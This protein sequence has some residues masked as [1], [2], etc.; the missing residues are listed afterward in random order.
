M[1]INK[2]YNLTFTYLLCLGILFQSC[3]K[4]LNIDPPISSIEQDLVF[5]N[6]PQATSAVVG[7]YSSMNSN[8]FASG[9]TTSVTFYAGMS[10]DDLIGY[11]TIL[12]FYENHLVAEL[13]EINALYNDFYRTIYKANVILEGLDASSS[14]SPPVKAQLQGE[15]YF[16]RSFANFYLVNLFGPIPLPLTSDYRTTE[17][18]PRS[19]VEA[20][21]A[22]ILSDLKKAESLLVDA[23]PGTGRSRPNK[24]V[25][26][27]LLARVYLYKQ[28]WINAE[29][30][31]SL[32]IDKTVDYNLVDMDAVFLTNSR[33]A[34]WQ[35]IPPTGNTNSQD[36]SALIPGLS[37]A[38]T[39]AS[40]TPDLVL[41]GFETGDKRSTTWIK[42][43]TIGS[44]VYYYPYKYKGI[45][46]TGISEST[47]LFRLAEQYLIRAEARINRE[48]LINGI[49]DLNK[50]R[51][52]TLPNG[53]NVNN[54]PPLLTTLTKSDAQFALEKERRREL[55]SEWGHRWFDLKRTGRADVVLS[56]IKPL[57]QAEYK[58]YPIPSDELNRNKN[59]RQ[60]DGY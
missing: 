22:Q 30:Y 58:L 52:R 39:K 11:N 32:V 4:F 15:T 3:K 5:Q 20:V 60:N 25:A 19:S 50:V 31:S 28:D 14:L 48:D 12:P 43:Y 38:P 36:G 21:Y 45:T 42:S 34:I 23:Y 29:T 10:S 55:F 41:N 1:K 51:Q 56:V 17:S 59:I 44:S 24:A 2:K 18:L 53:V 46:V 33:E 54:I 37:S 47:T 7:M 6:N 9:T 16:I 27:A 57:W 40:L 13:P 26:Q 49:K 35:L 8:G